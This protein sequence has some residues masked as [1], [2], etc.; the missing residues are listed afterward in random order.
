MNM[1]IDAG[2]SEGK[3]P[4]WAE[5]AIAV[6]LYVLGVSLL[7]FW[8]IQMP[9]EQTILRINVGGVVNGAVGLTA[10]YAAYLLRVRDWRAFGFNPTNPKWLL[11]AAVLGVVAFGLIFVVEGIYFHFITELNTQADFEAAAKGGVVSMVVL[12]FTSAVLGPIGEE[13]VFRGVIASA[14]GKYGSWVGVIGSAAIFG[15]VHGP[16]VI[17]LDAF[18]VGLFLGILYYRS[19]SIWPPIALHVVYNGLN[20]VYY[21][22]L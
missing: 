7:G 4:G 2:K 19:G 14:L 5:I 22:T 6:I 11:I 13:L 1:M 9:D 12:L 16:S 20:L 10:L 17:L 8:M 21:S 18:V 15:I 3:Q